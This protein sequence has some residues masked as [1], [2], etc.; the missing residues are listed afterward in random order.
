MFHGVRL[1]SCPNCGVDRRWDSMSRDKCGRCS[2]E[3][4]DETTIVFTGDGRLKCSSCDIEGVATLLLH[5]DDCARYGATTRGNWSETHLE[6]PHRQIA[7]TFETDFPVSQRSDSAKMTIA[8][9][10]VRRPGDRDR[11][12][13][14][15]RSRSPRSREPRSPRSAALSAPPPKNASVALMIPVASPKKAA[16]AS[17][18]K[19]AKVASPKKA[20]IAS[21]KKVAIASPKKAA[22]VA[23]P[24]KAK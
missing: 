11:G 19:A 4:S 5:A 17:P 2:F 10:R 18:K 15:S 13:S 7:H 16:I 21:P 23:S 9:T 8:R 1:T 22:K 24:K 3:F 20:A 14:R 12:R 6:S